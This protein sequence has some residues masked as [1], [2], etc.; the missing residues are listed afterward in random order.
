MPQLKEYLFKKA[1]N[2]D[3]AA[4]QLLIWK[5]QKYILSQAIPNNISY[6]IEGIHKR[7]KDTSLAN[8]N[9]EVV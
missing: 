8:T 7:V 5:G 4:K 6:W 2:A 3:Q 1:Q 9:V